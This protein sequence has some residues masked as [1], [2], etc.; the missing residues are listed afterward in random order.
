MTRKRWYRF[1]ASFATRAAC[2]ALLACAA[3]AAGA[4]DAAS[5]YA[6]LMAEV[7]SFTRYNAQ[8]EELL[9]SQQARI[10]GFE[11]QIAGLDGTRA[12]IE[13]LIQ[14]MFTSLEEFVAN[15]LPF[16]VEERSQRM[17]SLRLLMGEEG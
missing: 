5:E 17:D 11:S 2:A 3:G 4:Q 10:T 1:G 9:Q 13:P 15:D 7:D 16:L 8:L 12:A 14:K 6:S